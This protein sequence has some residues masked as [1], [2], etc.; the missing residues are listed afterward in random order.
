MA[1]VTELYNKYITRIK[2][3]CELYTVAVVDTKTS[4]VKSVAVTDKANVHLLSAL[5]EFEVERMLER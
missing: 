1:D 2:R 3:I 4:R 5:E